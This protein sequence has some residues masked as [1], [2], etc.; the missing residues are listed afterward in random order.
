MTPRAIAS[1]ALVAIAP[2]ATWITTSLTAHPSV[3]ALVPPWAE[4][5]GALTF[6]VLSLW[7]AA[8]ELF[9]RRRLSVVYRAALG[10]GVAAL[11]ASVLGFD[12]VSSSVAA[13]LFGAI[14]LWGSALRRIA[15]AG[16]WDALLIAFLCSGL[17][18]CVIALVAMVLRTPPELYAF[19]H[20]RAIGIFENPNELALFAL[21]VCAAA[22]GTMFLQSALRWLGAV[23][24]VVG[25][26]TLVATGSRSGEAAF[27]IGVIALGIALGTRRI[28]L[29]TILIVAIAGVG[30]SLWLDQRHNPADNEI[31]L[32]AWRAGIRTVKLFPLTGVGVGGYYRVYPMV[33]SPDAPGPEDPI[34]FDPHDF[35]LSV[36]A[37]TGLVGLAAFG[38]TIVA[39]VREARD[40]LADARGEGRRFALALLAG[41]LA[42]GCHLVFNA[43]ALSIVLWAVLAALTLGLPRS[44]YG[45]VE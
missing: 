42:M 10:F 34:A 18:L 27:A 43:F 38:W 20:G 15:A 5:I 28:H 17:I 11:L 25:L 4:R 21:S 23:T 32:S 14:A 30:L 8:A 40:A 9:L 7:L 37:E 36:A 35:Y 6:V 1:I 41:V 29:A 31:R 13:I 26:A 19:A 16:L 39:F 24:F 3:I 44:G 22:G 45:R 33:R 2:L 12:P